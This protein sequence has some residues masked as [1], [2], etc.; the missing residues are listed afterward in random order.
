M[1]TIQIAPAK[2]APP[3]P[4]RPN[5]LARMALPMFG[6]VGLLVC[7]Y[8]L[9]AL[10]AIP[11]Y[12]LPSPQSVVTRI[13]RDWKP[14]LD[15]TYQTSIEVI[16][17]FAASILVGVPLAYA[18]VMNRALE[19]ITLPILVA[20]QAVPKVAIAPIFVI[21]LGFGILPKIAIAFLIAF[22]PIVVSTVAGLKSVDLEMI[23]LVRSMGASK[24][25]IMLR[26][27]TPAAMPQI[28]SGLKVA[29]SLSVVGAIVG[30]FV[31]ADKGL[32]YIL[33]TATGNLDGPMTGAAMIFLIALGVGLYA[34]V[35]R[36]E[37]V[38]IRWHVSVRAD[39]MSTV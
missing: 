14:L 3:A 17:G 9:T 21:W 30:E 37:R 36:L 24:T 29:I 20:S 25:K 34:I 15:G 4:H 27:R 11:S 12:L 28:F 33:L 22:F 2:A 6:F 10:I 16:A 32:G 35:E 19:R 23:D 26:L 7:W 31:G 13:V 38:F 1:S 39:E 5:R 8:L 18:V